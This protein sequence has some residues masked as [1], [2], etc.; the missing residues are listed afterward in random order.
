M[1]L[2]STR[3][4]RRLRRPVRRTR[5]TAGVVAPDNV[6]NKSVNSILTGTSEIQRN[7]IAQGIA[8]MA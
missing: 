2:V 5:T 6:P 4:R 8:F 3:R 1:A 7:G